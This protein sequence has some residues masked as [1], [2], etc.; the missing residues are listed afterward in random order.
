V[1][2]WRARC[3]QALLAFALARPTL[4]LDPARPMGL[5]ERQRWCAEDGFPGGGVHAITQDGDGYLWLGTERGL[6][7]F[8]GTEFRLVAGPDAALAG[9]RD[10]LGVVVDGGGS[11]WMRPDGPA[12]LRY[13]DSRFESLPFAADPREVAVTAMTLGRGGELIAYAQVSGLLARRGERFER[14]PLG[15]IPRSIVLSMAET[16][17]GTLFLGTRD[18]G[19]FRVR[20][21]RI[22]PLLAGL[23]DRKVN[24]LV[25]VSDRDLWVGT[26]RGVVRWNGGELT[27]DRVPPALR[28]VQALALLRDRDA[29]V[30]VGTSTGLLRANG[31][32]AAG[33]KD[34][35]SRPAGAVSA[36]FEDREGDLWLGG[37]SGVERLHDTPFAT[38]TRA[39]GLPSDGG[40][41]IHVDRADRAWFAPPEGGLYR[42]E[43]ERVERVAVAGL[44]TDRVYSIAAAPDGL[45]LGRQ[46][47]G[48]TRLRL[49]STTLRARSYT[50]KDGLAQASVYA[51]H[52]G[53]DGSV[54]AGTLNRGLSRLRDGRIDTF[55]TASGLPSNS[56]ST[57]VDTHDGTLWVGTPAGLAAWSSGAWTTRRVADGLPSDNV[58]ALAEDSEGVLWIGTSGGL[59][60]LRSGR[61]ESPKAA[62]APLREAVLGLAEGESGWLWIATARRVMRVRREPLLGATFGD[63]DVVT[64]GRG[65]GLLGLEGVRG[66]RSVVADSHG[67]IWFSTNRGLS[68]VHP[69]RAM[70]AE[71][72]PLVHVRSLVA[73]DRPIGLGASLR[74]PPG[75]QRVRFAYTGVSLRAPERVRFRYRLDGFDARWS[76]PVTT[77]EAVYANL[78]PGPYRFRVVASGTDGLWNGPE[79]AVE[80]TIEP[81]VWQTTGF[82]LAAVLSVALCAWLLYA[83]RLGRA[84]RRLN[85]AFEERMAERTRIA[86]GL[87][88]TLLQGFVSASMQLHVAVE[89][90]PE[91]SPARALIARVQGLMAQVIE[92]GRNTVRELRSVERDTGDLA[93]DLSR[94]GEDMPGDATAELRVIVEGAPR[95][96]HPS[97]RDE[98]YR[99]G[100]EALVN[101]FLHARAKRIEVELEYAARAMRL[102]VR[103]DGIGV[104]PEVLRAGKDGHFGLSGMRERAERVGGRLRLWSGSGAGT[105]VEVVVRSAVAFASPAAPRRWGWPRIVR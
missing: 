102:L 91:A 15:T 19:L 65:D 18:A 62:P 7:R 55:T 16:P 25:A 41:T 84:T 31:Q 37:G 83:W 100:R 101:A 77:R 50:E 43:G 73:D 82:R 21:R 67:R 69:R 48:L 75:P 5:Y 56:V 45:W 90:V 78:G 88:D 95:A 96:L 99:I 32:G 89:Q 79:A 74:V 57:L 30:W 35:A 9:S 2:S 34:A 86:R 8:D 103:D 46:R 22:E 28:G 51:V 40:G 64:Y 49:G 24:C 20:E 72:P 63:A 27:Q 38:Y 98:L 6:V 59:A 80:L 13:R 14:V 87:H 44:G 29:N 97:V 11:L 54:W 58:T 26:D 10:V 23:P 61:V 1:S 105:E 39:Q 85:T 68:V 76:E 70:A 66:H 94:V 92:E 47:G 104:D 3:A 36:L 53:R 93:Q 60:F 81:A 33:L 4:A 52:E 71:A 17:D 12:L 42:L